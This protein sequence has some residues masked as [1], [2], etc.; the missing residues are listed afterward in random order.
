MQKQ[1]R[2]KV[3]D[4]GSADSFRRCLTDHMAVQFPVFQFHTIHCAFHCTHPC[5]YHASF[6]RRSRSTCSTQKEIPVSQYK[7]SVCSD[8][9]KCMNFLFFI[10]SGSHHTTDDISTKIIGPCRININISFYRQFQISRRKKSGPIRMYRIWRMKYTKRIHS[11]KKM[12]HCRIPTDR[13][14]DAAVFRQLILSFQFSYIGSNTV[15][16][17]FSKNFQ[18]FRIFLAVKDPGQ[19]IR[20]IRNL[21]VKGTDLS[22]N[23]SRITIHQTDSHCSTSKIHCHTI[24]FSRSVPGFQIH[25]F[26]VFFV[27]CQRHRYLPVR[28]FT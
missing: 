3:Y 7:L 23:L 6:Q 26:P 27:P 10:N 15:C 17:C 5:L 8:I 19:N 4:P 14:G 16:G 12:Y 21:T 18:C 24:M 22:Q 28:L 25:H 13:H 1:L 9:E 2:Q 20:P 11:K